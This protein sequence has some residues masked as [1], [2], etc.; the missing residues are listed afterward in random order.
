V[1][2]MEGG[3]GCPHWNLARATTRTTDHSGS[4][5][6][7]K[8][9]PNLPRPSHVAAINGRSHH[10]DSIHGVVASRADFQHS[11]TA[12]PV[13]QKKPLQV[14]VAF[15]SLENSSDLLADLR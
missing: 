10:A 9:P 4:F 13:Q 12:E 6:V 1:F 3:I 15:F 14:P 11:I 7:V 2:R 5:A 8:R